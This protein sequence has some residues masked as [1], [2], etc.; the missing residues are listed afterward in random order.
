MIHQVSNDRF[1]YEIIQNVAKKFKALEFLF[2]L[3]FYFQDFQLFYLC[4]KIESFHFIKE[5]H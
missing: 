4:F 5:M 2:R 1:D 3:L